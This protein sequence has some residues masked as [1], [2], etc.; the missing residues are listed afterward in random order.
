VRRHVKI[1]FTM[2]VDWLFT[3]FV[4]RSFTVILGVTAC[5]NAASCLYRAC[6]AG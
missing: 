2:F 3:G 6:H 1:F 4:E 5:W